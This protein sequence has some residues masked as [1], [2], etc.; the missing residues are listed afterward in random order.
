MYDGIPQNNLAKLCAESFLAAFHR[1][2]L[3]GKA[4]EDDPPADDASKDVTFSSPGFPP[5]LK[6]GNS[7]LSSSKAGVTDLWP[8]FFVEDMKLERYAASWLHV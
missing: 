3:G 8:L 1:A 5:K 4:N 2:D 6:R 7:A